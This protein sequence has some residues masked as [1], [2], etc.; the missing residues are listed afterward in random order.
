[1]AKLGSATGGRVNLPVS[2]K[3]NLKRVLIRKYNE[4]VKNSAE[5]D[6]KQINV[7]ISF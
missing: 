3:R 1:M 6:G 4:A 5:A 7:A 2:L